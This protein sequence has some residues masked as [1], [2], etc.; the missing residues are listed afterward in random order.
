VTLYHLEGSC[1]ELKQLASSVSIGGKFNVSEKEKG[2]LGKKTC[3]IGL[4]NECVTKKGNRGGGCLE[5]PET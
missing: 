2:A 4:E 3:I 5:G 1:E